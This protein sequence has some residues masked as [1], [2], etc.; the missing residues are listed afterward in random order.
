MSRALGPPRY[1]GV[2]DGG[3]GDISNSST[4][5]T[6]HNPNHEEYQYFNLI[7]TILISGE[8]RPDRIGI[9]TRSIFTPSQLRFL[10]LKPFISGYILSLLLSNQGFLDKVGLGHRN[11]DIKTSYTG[12]GI[13][14]FTE[15]IHKLKYNLFNCRIII[16]AWNPADLKK[17]ALPP[18][19][20]FTY[21]SGYLYCQLYQRSCN[22]TLGVLFNITF[23]TLLTHILAYTTDLLPGTF[24]Y[25]IPLQEQ[26][27][28]EPTK[29]PI[30]SLKLINP[31]LV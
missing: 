25:T 24:V 22:I 17:M 23:Y 6:A 28:R 2:G 19:Y 4:S 30:I 21:F 26:L 13:N 7:R 5:N 16:S 14:R 3:S 11:V 8:H 20:M 10:L 29:F 9:G 15:I 31:E 18:C 1:I 27:V 12:Q